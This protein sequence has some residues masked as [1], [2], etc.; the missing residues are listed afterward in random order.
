M[1]SFKIKRNCVRG[2][3]M[4]RNDSIPKTKNDSIANVQDGDIDPP[5]LI[6]PKPPKK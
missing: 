5:F 2:G 6:P 1:W 4:R 3:V